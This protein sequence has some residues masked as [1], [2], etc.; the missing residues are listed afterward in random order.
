MISFKNICILIIQYDIIIKIIQILI[1]I[2]TLV[3]LLSR[4]LY[5]K[6]ANRYSQL[7][8]HIISRRL[9]TIKSI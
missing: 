5:A 9:N 1:K 3:D 2:N 4:D 8:V 7:V 6:I